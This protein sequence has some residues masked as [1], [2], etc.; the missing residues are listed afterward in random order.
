M[1]RGTE[2]GG[3]AADF[4]VFS[5]VQGDE[6]SA[7]AAAGNCVDFQEFAAFKHTPAHLFEFRRFEF[8]A[9]AD[10]IDFED[11]MAGMGEAR[12]IIAVVGEQNQ[13]FAVFVEPSR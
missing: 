3:Q 10:L 5:L 4:P 11:F 1:G 12:H 8:A 6:I 2:R 7:V 9:D 13:P